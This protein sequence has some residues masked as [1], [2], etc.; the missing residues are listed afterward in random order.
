M[1]KTKRL[2]QLIGLAIFIA[3]SFTFSSCDPDD[4][5]PQEA[6]ITAFAITNTGGDSDTRV[7]GVI[8]GMN[9]LVVVPYET[10]VTALTPNITVSEGATVVPASGS[11]VDFSDPRSFVVTNGDLN[12]TYQV[13]VDL[14]DP[15]SGVISEISI[16]S[17]A[18]SE[19]YETEINQGDK[20]ITVTFNDLQSTLGVIDEITLLPAGT[21]YTTS[22]GTDTLDLTA[23]PTITLSYADAETVYTIVSNITAAGFNV[24]NTTSLVNF[25]SAAGSVP[26]IID[27]ELS[28]SAAFNGRYVF[29][30]T[31]KDGNS[32][33]FWDVENPGDQPGTL[34]FGDIVSGGTWLISDVAV[35]GDNIYVSN[36]AW[37]QDG[38]FKIYKW[39]GIDDPEPEL[40]LSYTLP[41]Q[42]LRLGDAIS[43]IG[44][45]PSDGYIFASN[46]P[47]LPDGTNTFASEFYRW[48]FNDG[49]NTEPTIVEINPTLTNSLGQYGRVNSIPG[50]SDHYL[51]S[52]AEMTVGVIDIDGN[53]VYELSELVNGGLR[54][55][56]P[57]IFEYNGGRYLSYT[58]NN[59][60]SSTGAYMEIV[61][62]TG[63]ESVLDGLMQL[64]ATNIAD[65]K[66]YQHVFGNIADIWISATNDVGF[67]TEG[68]PRV[69]SFTVQN[70]FVVHEFSN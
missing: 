63:P 70:G 32:V 2:F 14:A 7:E 69:M 9:I 65:R 42:E 23:S 54:A 34:N 20:T 61:N 15:T 50:E 6:L 29:A 40:I 56:D 52:G 66:V 13:T 18:S 67:S 28:R 24:D 43:V 37:G 39:E 36:M 53:M 62:I 3:A 68:K 47:I 59:E 11:E 48:N 10:D 51:V 64:N 5:E 41:I 60:G 12:N 49:S 16:L 30:P 33:V 46:F 55:Y 44:N 21:S 19:P 22:S 45:P 26:S 17:G 8:E 4:P 58:F 25:S 57:N 1:K 35:K 31:R 38:V 27:D